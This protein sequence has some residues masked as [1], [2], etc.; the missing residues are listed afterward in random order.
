MYRV[1]VYSWRNLFRPINAAFVELI[2][3]LC[4]TFTH[5][6]YVNALVFKA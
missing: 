2:C 5:K 6:R 4:I 3:S 1:E